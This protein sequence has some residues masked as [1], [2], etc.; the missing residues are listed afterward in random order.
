MIA[1]SVTIGS[2]SF[3]GT[4]DSKGRVE[5]P[6]DAKLTADNNILQIKADGLNLQDLLPIDPTDGNHTV[7][8]EIKVTATP[9]AAGSQALTLSDQNVTFNYRVRHGRAQGRSE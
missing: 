4:A 2:A 6:F 8:V 3:T 7:T 9:A 5:T 1:A